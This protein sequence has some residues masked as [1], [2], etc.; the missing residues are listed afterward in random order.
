MDVKDV[1]MGEVVLGL[2][3]GHW[4]EMTLE[5][6]GWKKWSSVIPGLVACKPPEVVVPLPRPEDIAPLA[7]RALYMLYDSDPY[8]PHLYGVYTSVETMLAWVT[9]SAQGLQSE[10]GVTIL[11]WPVSE[12]VGHRHVL[13][14]TYKY[15]GRYNE[16]TFRGYRVV[17]DSF[18][19]PEI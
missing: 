5:P 2:L 19:H 8:H 14:Y 9:K 16:R 11:D 12:K 3:N 7:G 4:E 1:N 10:E 15:E 6:E 18:E 13:Q 17:A